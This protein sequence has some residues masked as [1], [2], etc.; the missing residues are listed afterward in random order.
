MRIV[1]FLMLLSLTQTATASQTGWLVQVKPQFRQIVQ[2]LHYSPMNVGANIQALA[3]GQH[4]VFQGDDQSAAEL[5]AQPWVRNIEKNKIYRLARIPNDPAFEKSWNLNNQ[6]QA[7]PLGDIGKEGADVHVL[8][9]WEKGF[10]GNSTIKVAV[11]DSGVEY[12]HSDL[13]ENIWINKN[14][15]PNNGL[16]DD[17]NGFVDDYYGWDFV[18]KDAD[19]KDEL[20]HGT[21]CAGI[22]GARG[23]DGQGI[24]GVNWQVSIMSIRAFDERG[25]GE[26][27]DIVE[28]LYYAQLMGA[29]VVNASWGGDPYS[30]ILHEAISDL[31]KS[32]ILF[33]AA[34][35]NDSMDNDQI[36][37]Y[38]AN[39]DLKNIISVAA[40]DNQD[41][42]ANFSHYGAKT[43][44]I[45]APGVG[46]YSTVLNNNY[47]AYSGTSMAAPHVAGVAALLWS[48]FPEESYLQIKNR[49]LKGAD[50]SYSLKRKILSHG[51]LNAWNSYLNIRSP[52][53]EPDQ[54]NWK[55][56]NAKV[57]SSHPYS[58]ADKSKWELTRP[59]AAYVR[60]HFSKI[61]LEEGFDKIQIQKADGTIVE[62]ISF[63]SEDYTSESV[64]GDKIIIQM[65]ADL[66]LE[67]WGFLIDR[68]EWI[69]K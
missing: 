44:H 42:L 50:P 35:G 29:Q 37:F 53:A 62:E 31:E 4:F 38:P 11:I 30:Q 18:K 67:K 9:L 26:L 7:S 33:V 10:T 56:Q 61:D 41:Q 45:A 63:N 59:G 19:P 8:P 58:S 21:H 1:L 64:M 25:Q 51:R 66:S 52:E 34:A 55:K 36:P 6:G 68:L 2:S 69:D 40:T 23:N 54:T 28:A 57:E 43:V 22:I 12:T 60:V 20:G 39:Y 15:L 5:R 65:K 48:I 24:A 49:L 13:K 46:V 16:D 32:G 27:A 17:H 3:T 14:E 47:D